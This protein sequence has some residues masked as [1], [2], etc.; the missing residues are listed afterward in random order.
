MT[1]SP[2][3]GTG[4]PPASAAISEGSLVGLL[5][6]IDEHREAALV[7][8]QAKAQQKRASRSLAAGI[9]LSRK[10]SRFQFSAQGLILI[11]T[12]YSHE[13]KTATIAV[14]PGSYGVLV[15]RVRVCRSSYPLSFEATASERT[16]CETSCLTDTEK[17]Q[18][19]VG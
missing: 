9:T 5:R 4:L 11:S 10:F 8:R 13:K 19:G 16:P 18:A 2:S 1:R 14:H 6:L 3:P 17:T 7:G 12:W 15:F